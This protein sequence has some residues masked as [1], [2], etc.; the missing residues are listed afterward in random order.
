M[1]TSA[2]TSTSTS[3]SNKEGVAGSGLLDA[4]LRLCQDGESAL[5]FT[6]IYP[7]IWDVIAS[8]KQLQAKQ[9]G[10]NDDLVAGMAG[11]RLTYGELLT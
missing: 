1:A 6:S 3:G 7:C 10:A 4:W 2:P 8:V 9:D 5:T 11:K